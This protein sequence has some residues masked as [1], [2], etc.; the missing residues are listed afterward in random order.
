M[1]SIFYLFLQ[2]LSSAC[3]TKRDGCGASIEMLI[4]EAYFVCYYCMSGRDKELFGLTGVITQNILHLFHC[5]IYFLFY[6][7]RW[8]DRYAVNCLNVSQLIC[9]IRGKLLFC[10]EFL[11]TLRKCGTLYLSQNPKIMRKYLFLYAVAATVL[12]VYGYRHYRA[13][14]RRL[15]Q[16]QVT[17]SLSADHYRTRLG[18]EAA[19]V[20]ALRLRCAEYKQLRAEDAT[21]IQALGLKIRRLESVAKTA[22]TTTL[23][24]RTVLRDTV[25]LHDTLRLFRWH[26]TWVTVEGLIC[27]DSVQCRVKSV[28][29]LRQ[30]VHRIPRRFL[31]FRWGTKALRQEIV[32]SNPHTHII[33]TDYVKIER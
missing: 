20:Q 10:F 16:N 8:I 3:A 6:E 13:E 29:T 27:A 5:T 21:C 23:E 22:T 9:C 17:M 14:N 11:E 25:I 32:S 2:L 7:E 19:S 1:C 28:D 18:K 4:F 33:Y 12:I 24:V 30:I 31:F 15:A 26:D